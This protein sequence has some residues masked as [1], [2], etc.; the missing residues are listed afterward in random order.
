M[1]CHVQLGNPAYVTCLV[2]A[3]TETLNCS[4]WISH[5]SHL[6]NSCL[7]YFSGLLQGFGVVLSLVPLKLTTRTRPS[8]HVEYQSTGKITVST[9]VFSCNWPYL[10]SSK[11]DSTTHDLLFSCLSVLDLVNISKVNRTASSAVKSYRKRAYN[12]AK[13]LSRYFTD[14]FV[15]RFRFVQARTGMLISGSAALQ[16]FDRTF[17]KNSDL[18]LYVEHRHCS[19]AAHFLITAGY[20]F[21]PRQGQGGLDSEILEL[22]HYW[23]EHDW[24]VSAYMNDSICGVFTF[25]KGDNKIQLITA[26]ESPLNIILAFHSS[27]FSAFYSILPF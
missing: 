1:L 13:F 21:R 2:F 15:H 11:L 6:P 16:F 20:Q 19:E 5:R 14:D 12:I 27:R 10:F 18:D 23:E 22:A 7:L 8:R 3:L 17:Y 9:I 25:E 24:D 4:H 26:R